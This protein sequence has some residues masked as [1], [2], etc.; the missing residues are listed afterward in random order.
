MPWQL[1]GHDLTLV[2]QV[3]PGA[4]SSA[5]AGTYGG[6]ALRLRLAAPAVDGRANRACVAFL[7]TS[8]GVPKS[9]VTILRGE[10]A[11]RKVVRIAGVSADGVA[12]LQD[13]WQD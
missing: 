7:A 8:L 13:Q 1:D 12:R 4:A 6:T 9:R 3:Q 10:H 11:R 5:W 2:L